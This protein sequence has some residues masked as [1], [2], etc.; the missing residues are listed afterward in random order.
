M[1]LSN[2]GKA[3]LQEKGAMMR[4][5]TGETPGFGY[6]IRA[7]KGAAGCYYGSG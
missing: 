2:F 1:V 7:Q 3:A 6:C 5:Q 4:V